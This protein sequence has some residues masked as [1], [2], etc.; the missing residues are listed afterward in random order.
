MKRFLLKL[1]R[2]SQWLNH[3]SHF[4]LQIIWIRNLIR[5]LPLDWIKCSIHV[6][7]HLTNWVENG[8]TSTLNILDFGNFN[9]NP[10]TIHS[11]ENHTVSSSINQF[12]ST[13][14]IGCRIKFG[15]GRQWKPLKSSA[16]LNDYHSFAQLVWWLVFCV[17]LVVFSNNNSPQLII[18]N[19]VNIVGY[20]LYS[21]NR[22]WDYF[23]IVG[24]TVAFVVISGC[25]HSHIKNK[26]CQSRRN[27]PAVHRLFVVCGSYLTVPTIWAEF[28]FD[29]NE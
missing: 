22:K 20:V 25:D 16:A 26:H 4:T 27:I 13:I 11:N 14:F 29:R 23:H 5:Q 24:T 10:P 8:E 17:C 6:D 1:F 18:I 21:Y 19:G 3:C 28:Q 12:A 9:F 7:N 2:V 15:F